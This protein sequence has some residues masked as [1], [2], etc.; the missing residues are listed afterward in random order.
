MTKKPITDDPFP[1]LPR[2]SLFGQDDKVTV[3]SKPPHGIDIPV[4]VNENDFQ[5]LP[6]EPA[7]ILAEAEKAAAPLASPKGRGRPKV[8]GMRPWEAEGISKA[9]YY[10]R[11]AKDKTK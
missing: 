7:Y 3:P 8:E 6:P 10:R 1:A 9:L 5:D 4:A 2:R 11:R